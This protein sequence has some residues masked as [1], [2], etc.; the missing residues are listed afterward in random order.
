M[1]VSRPLCDQI[2][3]FHACVPCGFAKGEDV[4]VLAEAAGASSA[5]DFFGRGAQAGEQENQRNLGNGAQP[6]VW[7][8]LGLGKPANAMS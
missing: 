2:R 7:K 8:H 3:P 5:M 4:E 6:F 1:V